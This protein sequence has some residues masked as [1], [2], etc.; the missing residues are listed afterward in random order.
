[1]FMAGDS[2][3]AKKV[4]I[5]LAIDA[6]FGTCL[7]FEKSDKVA[8]LEKFALSR[9]NLAIMQGQGRNIAFKIIRR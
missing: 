9:I 1:M 3:T 8:L 4:A 2:D 7:D 5:Q 6:G